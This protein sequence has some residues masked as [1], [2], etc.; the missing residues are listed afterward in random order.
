MK[1]LATSTYSAQSYIYDALGNLTVK[2]T[3]KYTYAGTGY[4]NPDAVT[5]VA[6]GT[7]TSSFAYD[8]N[9]NLTSA[10]SSTFSWDYN[11]RMTQAVTAGSATST[12]SYDYAGN[13]VTQ[14]V[15]STTTVYPNKYYSITSTTNG[16]TTT[17]TTTVYVWNGDTL[18]A[19]IDQVTVNGANSGTS[20]T[21]YIHPDHLGSTNI[22][23]DESGSV[24][25]SEECIPNNSGLPG[26]IKQNGITYVRNSSGLLNI[27]K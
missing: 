21:R 1:M 19:T 16:A 25:T 7:A 6:N 22:V 17:A 20:S 27:A 3:S 12:Y 13:R 18:I 4:A 9:G 11:N 23:S 5:Q 26:A 15:G 2:A 8:N 14:V 24:V 10:G